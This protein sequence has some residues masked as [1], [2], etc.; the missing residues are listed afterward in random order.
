MNFCNTAAEANGGKAGN[1]H[2]M[3]NFAPQKTAAEARRA[4]ELANTRRENRNDLPL[5]E[6]RLCAAFFAIK[7]AIIQRMDETQ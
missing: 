4:A 5:R 6:F 2:H 1:S 7:R 3:A